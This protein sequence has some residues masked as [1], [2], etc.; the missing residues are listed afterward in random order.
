MNLKPQFLIK[1]GYYIVPSP[2]TSLEQQERGFTHNLTDLINT[3]SLT[4]LVNQAIS[5]MVLYF[6]TA[7]ENCW[8]KPAFTAIQKYSRLR[9]LLRVKGFGDLYLFRLVW[10]YSINQ[11]HKHYHLEV[12]ANPKKMA[13]K[14]WCYF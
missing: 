1:S 6:K 10:Q 7:A 3:F 13:Q 4:N 5:I 2:S 8:C 9:C 11:N 14:N 12:Q